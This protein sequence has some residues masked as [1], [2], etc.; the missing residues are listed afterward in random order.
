VQLSAGHF[1]TNTIFVKNFKGC[2][3]GAGEGKTVIDTLQALGSGEPV[4]PVMTAVEPFPF[5]FGFQGGN[6]R[7]SGMS[8][9]ITASSPAEGW[10]FWEWPS[11][12]LWSVFLVTGSAS[13]SFDQ[14]GFA[15]G[16]GDDWDGYNVQ[17]DIQITGAWHVDASGDPTALAPTGGCDSVTR[18]VFA[19]D[20]GIWTDGLTAGRLTVGGSAANQNVFSE[21]GGGCMLTDNSNSGIAVSHNQMRCSAGGSIFLWQSYANPFAPPPPLPAPRYLISDNNILANGAA[22]GMWLEDDSVG[23]GDPACLNATIVDNNI[24]LDNG[25]NDAG[26]DGFCAQGI[27][28][29]HNRI[30]GTGLAGID[31]GTTWWYTDLTE[32]TSGW[33][34]IGNDV[35][36]V[37]ATGDQYGVSTAQIWLGPL[38]THCLVVG[39]KAPTEVFDQG[40]DDTLINV[41]P[42]TDPPA[43]AA[44]P[45]N[46]LKQLKQPK[47]T[48]RP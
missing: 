22:N 8:C 16:T 30:S 7:V 13:S 23:W 41:T 36:G 42:V 26:I 3:R 46:S 14:V 6:V 39:G 28:V 2:L 11:T 29:L 47:G 43:A 5:L 20:Y 21:S 10:S 40:T 17:S 15:A 44:M 34:I 25:G 9:D 1:Y 35:S 32:P 18:C 33:Q 31:V 37:T 48:M 19:G 12:A 27:L 4:V 45:T 24:H 38:A